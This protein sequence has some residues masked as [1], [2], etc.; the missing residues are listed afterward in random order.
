LG[1]RWTEQLFDAGQGQVFH[2]PGKQFAGRWRHWVA[3]VPPD[4]HRALLARSLFRVWNAGPEY[5]LSRAKARGKRATFDLWLNRFI[6]EILELAFCWNEQFVPHLKW[7]VAHFCRL[8]ICPEAVRE[9]IEGLWDTS[10]LEASI[11]IAETII[12]SVKLLMKDL[13]HL[14]PDLEEPLS[15]FAHALHDTI[16]DPVVRK[17]TSLDW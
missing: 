8:P 17:Q 2:D 15:A 11:G 10:D 16:E 12:T 5:N 14:G 1:R 4:I 6:E 9:G 3:Y 13:Y 7:R